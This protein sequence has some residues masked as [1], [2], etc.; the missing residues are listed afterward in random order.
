MRKGW[1]WLALSRFVGS[2]ASR[3]PSRTGRCRS[4]WRRSHLFGR[5]RNSLTCRPPVAPGRWPASVARGCLHAGRGWTPIMWMV[6][7]PKAFALLWGGWLPPAG[8]WRRWIGIGSGG[9]SWSGMNSSGRRCACSLKV[10]RTRAA[11]GRCRAFRMREETQPIG[12][13]A[14]FCATWD[15]DWWSCSK[16]AGNRGREGWGAG[17][18]LCPGLDGRATGGGGTSR[19]RR[20]SG[21]RRLGMPLSGVVPERISEHGAGQCPDEKLRKQFAACPR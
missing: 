15:G 2:P 14:G 6:R 11:G 13:T 10:C 4:A 21:G 8:G 19:L 16:A 17:G 9:F 1:P 3:A 12:N 18:G 20:F 5:C 7:V